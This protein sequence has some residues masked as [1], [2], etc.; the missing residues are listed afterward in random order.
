MNKLSVDQEPTNQKISRL[1][2]ST[3]QKYQ[4]TKKDQLTRNIS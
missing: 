3:D 1:K 2:R 4:L